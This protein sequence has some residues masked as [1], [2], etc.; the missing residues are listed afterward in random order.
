MT[1]SSCDSVFS[2]STISKKNIWTRS[3][4]QNID[5]TVNKLYDSII[6]K[7]ALE[8]RYICNGFAR[9]GRAD[10]KLLLHLIDTNAN[11][12]RFRAI[13][14][15]RCTMHNA[16]IIHSHARTNIITHMSAR[17]H[18]NNTIR[19][20]SPDFFFFYFVPRNY[21]NMYMIHMHTAYTPCVW[22]AHQK[23]KKQTHRYSVYNAMLRCTVTYIIYSTGIILVFLLNAHNIVCVCLILI[24]SLSLILQSVSNQWLFGK[25]KHFFSSFFFYKLSVQHAHH[26]VFI[27]WHKF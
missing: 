8:T 1:T 7:R 11:C 10:D 26:I 14:A 13:D 3:R 22:S 2:L 6:S 20:T 27:P 15:S 5:T 16:H 21:I 4:D 24:A 19:I 18:H 25:N 12:T 9:E 17:V 23:K